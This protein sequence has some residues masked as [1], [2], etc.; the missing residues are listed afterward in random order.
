MVESLYNIFRNALIVIVTTIFVAI[1]SSGRVYASD[2]NQVIAFS[3]FI[4][5]IYTNIDTS[6][7]GDDFCI[8]GSDDV[9]L[10]ISTIVKKENIIAI[11]EEINL[12]IDYS[13]CKV[14]YVAKNKEKDAKYYAQFFSDKGALTLGLFHGFVADGG[15]MSIGIGR[16]NFELTVNGPLLKK[17]GVK[18]DSSIASLIVE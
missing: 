14:I 18:I 17:S 16:R 6:K 11:G 12:K 1:Y 3:G 5:H 4:N 7:N 2:I 8:F 9:S 15:M 13:K 10:Y